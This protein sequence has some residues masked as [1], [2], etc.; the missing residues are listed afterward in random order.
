MS[1]HKWDVECAYGNISRE[2]G[3]LTGLG[4]VRESFPEK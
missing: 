3:Y 4:D 1:F 2:K